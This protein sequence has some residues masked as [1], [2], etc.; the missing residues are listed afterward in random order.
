MKRVLVLCA[1][2]AA[3]GWVWGQ[4]IPRPE[5]VLGFPVGADRKLADWQQIVNYFQLLAQSSPRIQVHDLGPTTLDNPFLLTVISKPETLADL[6]THR[7]VQERLADPRKIGDSLEELIDRGKTIVLVTCA[8][9]STEVASAQ[10]SMELAY[11]LAAGQ[12]AETL[13]ILDNVILLLVPALNPDGVNIVNHWYWKTLGTAA[14]GTSP[15]ELYH[16]YAGHDNNRDWYMFTQQETRIAIE[17]IHNVWHPQIVFDVHQMGPYGARLF[18]PPFIDP[19]EPNVDPILQAGIV[20]LGGALFSSL[21]QRGKAG[22]VTNAIYDAY[23]PARAYQHYHGGVRIL[24]EAASVRLATPIELERYQLLSGRN[25]DVRQRS[26]NYPLP[27]N[28]GTWR[29]RDIVEYEKIAVRAALLHGARNRGRWLRSFYEVG[30]Q[31]VQRSQPYAFVLPA[32]QDDPQSLKDLVDVLQFG[33]V[34]V[35]RARQPFRVDSTKLESPPHGQRGR[36]DFP[37]GS[38]LIPMQQPY[39]SFA[40]TLLEVQRYPELRQYPGG[41]LKRPYDVTAHTLGIQLG[42]ETYSTEVA[43][44]VDS[45]ILGPRALPQERF[46]GEGDYWLFSHTN[47]ASVLA[48]NRLLTSGNTVYWAPNGFRVG[49][50]GFAVGTFMAR[51]D[52][53]QETLRGSLRGLPISVRQ[54]DR[55]PQL[56]WQRIRGPRIGLYKSFA[57]SI[58][59]GWTRWT[60]EE[61][62]F[63]YKSLLNRDIQ[64]ADLTEYDVIV[65]PHQDPELI[66]GGLGKPYPPEYRGGI[67]QQGLNRLKQ[68]MEKGGTVVLLGSSTRLASPDWGIEVGD[69]TGG[70]S[71]RHLY[72]PGSLLRVEVNNRH[73]LGY[74][75]PAEA[76]VMFVKSPA[77]D[78]TDEQ[79]VVRYSNKDLLLSGWI[80]GQEHL[81]GRSALGL[82]RLG[83]GRLILIGFRTQFRAQTRGTYKFLFNSLYWATTAR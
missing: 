25:Y 79:S 69:V 47:N 55:R 42:V 1:L 44:D 48:V 27:W 26:W 7:K 66:L 53:D 39:S 67:E 77:F 57:P 83:K 45:D 64:E 9:H 24:S 29:L 50:E 72:V 13:E 62:E 33:M 46:E 58:D 51:V 30:R 81:Q 17:Q 16:A 73:P 6:E 60:L 76:A 2:L 3:Q 63:P 14:E 32:D 78:L 70:L 34:E 49:A 15:P 43:F 74:G 40:K 54:V 82:S 21:I 61:Y 41:P 59:E 11:D 19:I 52:R 10:M 35:H 75:M 31:A 71:S 4:D 38:Y 5:E 37:A 22:V 23:T 20:E 28:G 12:D 18:V 36:V 65:I 80:E 8:I 56:A 68:F